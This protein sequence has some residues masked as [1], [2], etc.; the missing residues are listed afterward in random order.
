MFLK[1][2]LTMRNDI[3]HSHGWCMQQLLY[4]MYCLFCDMFCSLVYASS[5]LIN[6]EFEFEYNRRARCTQVSDQCLIIKQQVYG[7]LSSKAI[8]TLGSGQK[9][10]V[11]QVTGNRHIFLGIILISRGMHVYIF[12]CV[13]LV[14]IINKLREGNLGT[15]MYVHAQ[16]APKLTDI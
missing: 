3:L 13:Q 12:F 11:G 9:I 1:T 6:K 7:I 15:I 2:S 4:T 8:K 14:W 5:G 16:D 10:R